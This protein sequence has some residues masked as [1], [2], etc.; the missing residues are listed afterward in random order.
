[1]EENKI[2]ENMISRDAIGLAV[3][4]DPS[5]IR[6]HCADKSARC[7]DVMAIMLRVYGKKGNVTEFS[8]RVTLPSVLYS[9]CISPH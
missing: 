8:P 3:N 7:N 9:M 6:L 2:Y 4:A 1:M 5:P